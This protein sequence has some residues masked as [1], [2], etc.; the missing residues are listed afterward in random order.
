VSRATVAKLALLAVL[1]ALGAFLAGSVKIAADPEDFRAFY[2]GGRMVAERHDPYLTEPLRTCEVSLAR[3]AGLSPYPRLAVPVPLPG[4]A[5]VPFAALSMLPPHPA[6]VLYLL[7]L[8]VALVV[9]AFWLRTLSGAPLAGIVAALLLSDGWVSIANGQLVPIAVLALCGC[10][11]E[12]SRGRFAGAS[13]YA[14]LAS[15]EPHVALPLWLS[16]AVACPKTRAPLA[17]GAVLLAVLSLLAIGLPANV[18]YLLAVLPAHA[19]AEAGAGSQYSLTAVLVHGG[20][21][22]GTAI[23]LANGWYAAMIILGIG[24]ARRLAAAFDAPE[25]AALVPPAFA[26]FGAPFL[27]LTQVAVAI[28]AL[29]VLGRRVPERRTGFGIALLLLALPWADLAENAAGPMLLAIAAV[30]A[31]L[32]LSMWGPH[33]RAVVLAMATMLVLGA[34]EKAL[35]AAYGERSFDASAALAAADGGGAQLAETTWQAFVAVAQDDDPRLY[36][37]SHLPT[38]LGLGLMI[39]ATASVPR[40]R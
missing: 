35:N 38:W 33:V 31:A 13:A 28:P 1:V 24:V 12:L 15:I 17:A 3:A 2:C 20:L 11:L 39:V 37:G 9:S 27:H 22:S 18:E 8:V 26:L 30:T 6:T 19:Q 4:F 36:F 25:L 7:L 34:S 5:F 40:R 16:L 23:V 10:A 29:L 14:L 21:A 32:A